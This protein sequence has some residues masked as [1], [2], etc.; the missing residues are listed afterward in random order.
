MIYALFL[1]ITNIAIATATDENL[2][3]YKIKE[4]ENQDDPG[5]TVSVYENLFERHPSDPELA[6][7]LARALNAQGNYVGLVDHLKKWV[8]SNS[9][10]ELAILM[11]GDAYIK[12][13]KTGKAIEVWEG[14]LNS[15]SVALGTYRK[16]S[17]RCES[18]GLFKEA[19]RFLEKGR[20]VND[21][22]NL[23][24]WEL[25][26]LRMRVGDIEEAVQLYL[27]IIDQDKNL[28]PVVEI[29][30][31]AS[32]KLENSTLFKT[33]VNRLERNNRQ[34]KSLSLV[35]LIGECALSMDR[36]LDGYLIVSEFVEQS[37]D[38]EVLYQYANKCEK[39]G[40]AEVAAA[41][42]SFFATNFHES[43]NAS[44]ALQRSV[45]IQLNKGDIELALSDLEKL[46]S[47]SP[48]EPEVQ[49]MVVELAEFN[50]TSENQSEKIVSMLELVEASPTRGPLVYKAL[51]LL[52]DYALKDG[53]LDDTRIY[54]ERM[55][56]IGDKED[57]E[58]GARR[59]ELLYFTSGCPEVIS[60]IDPLIQANVDHIFA[61]DALEIM[62]ICEEFGAEP[63]WNDLKRAQLLERQALFDE[64]ES[65]WS[66]IFDAV[67]PITRERLM[68]IRARSAKGSARALKFF[69]RLVEEFPEG[70]FSS[71]GKLALAD[72]HQSAGRFREALVLCES[73][74]LMAPNDF[75][76]PEFRLRIQRLRE[77][78]NQKESQQ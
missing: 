19:I 15:P 72:L 4:L 70:I 44:L 75:Q 67:S 46:I 76:A 11:L 61:N 7:G 45:R 30:V 29:E 22:K 66:A 68:L 57:Y 20:K 13:G 51:G 58:L 23:F 27:N 36:P 64:S 8:D 71:E 41:S 65:T 40:F 2:L 25:A 32:C 47:M 24:V 34:N 74:L 38:L 33:L 53:R 39:R 18:A 1:T 55:E 50:E 59:A 28:F 9:V 48:N 31:S 73:G 62:M 60:Q 16:L 54:V 56:E 10:D 42:Y 21:R 3:R 37:G 6:H 69:A 14:L 52:A 78:L 5:G 49:Q 77:E 26:K 43:A 17:D 63:F 35:R 12:L